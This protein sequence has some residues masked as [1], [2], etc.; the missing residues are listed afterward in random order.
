MGCIVFDELEKTQSRILTRQMDRYFKN[1]AVWRAQAS[2]V[3]PE[4]FFVHSDLT[5]GIQLADIVAYLV[6]W[7]LRFGP[8]SAP[9]RAELAPY[10][11]LLKLMRYRFV[12]RGAESSEREVEYDRGIRSA[13]GIET[14]KKAMPVSR[15]EP[16]R[17]NL[18]EPLKTLYNLRAMI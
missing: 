17:M 3:I 5:T 4:P 9:A 16:P 10:N 18:R 1:H 7:G 8:L 12:E 15:T 6:S 2:R 14:I 13:G 11:D